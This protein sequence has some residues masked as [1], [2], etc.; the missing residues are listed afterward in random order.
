MSGPSARQIFQQRRSAVAMDGRSQ[1]DADRFYQ[2]LQRCCP[3]HS[4]PW[5]SWPYA[6]E[7]HLALFVHRVRG[8]D[9]GLYILVRNLD[10][11]GQLR[12]ALSPSFPWERPERCPASLPLYR[13]DRGNLQDLAA[14]LCCQQEIAGDGA[15][16]V[17]M[18]CRFQ[19]VLDSPWRYRR[20]FWET[21]MI[22]QVLYLEAE[23]AGLRGTGIGC[24]FDDAVHETLGI[25]DNSFQSL[26]H[27]TLGGPVED[28]RLRT[29]PPYPAER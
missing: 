7:V 22:G 16:M 27:F 28:S 8:L 21:G 13:L 25:A 5:W 3:G 15:F 19:A 9:P 4:A 17:G 26:Y 1:L 18:I 2:I 10:H 24:F 14:G 20:L 12:Q 29:L 6:P 23:A 11:E